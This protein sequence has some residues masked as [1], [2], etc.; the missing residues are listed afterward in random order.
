MVYLILGAIVI[1]ALGIPAMDWLMRRIWPLTPEQ[2]EARR[3][4]QEMKRK[5]VDRFRR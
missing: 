1:V 4:A 5:V 3:L 2:E